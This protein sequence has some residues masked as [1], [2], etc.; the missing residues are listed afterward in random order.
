MIGG[1]EGDTFFGQEGFDIFQVYGGVNWIM[2]F[3]P[4]KYVVYTIG[5]GGTYRLSNPVQVGDHVH[6]TINPG[7]GIIVS[8]G[9]PTA[10]GGDLYLAWTTVAEVEADILIV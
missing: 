3:E 8:I 1:K 7:A 9:E 4:G 5:A 6:V 2:D 10:P